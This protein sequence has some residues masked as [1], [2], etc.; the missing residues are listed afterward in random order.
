M[1]R[2]DLVREVTKTAEE[3]QLAQNLAKA[4]QAK[5]G[6]DEEYR[7]TQRG[8]SLYHLLEEIKDL[9]LLD[10]SADRGA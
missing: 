6:F 10:V 7:Q 9:S 3:T 8:K 4:N 2:T 1:S 5:D